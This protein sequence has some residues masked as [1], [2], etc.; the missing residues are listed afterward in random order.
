MKHLKKLLWLLP[1]SFMFFSCSNAV[2]E[3]HKDVKAVLKWEAS[4]VKTFEPSIPDT[5]P[6]DLVLALRHHSAVKG[7]TLP[8]KCT[9]Q[10]PSDFSKETWVDFAVRDQDGVLLGSVAGDICDTEMTFLSGFTF[11]EAGTYTIKVE[12]VKEDGN[13]IPGMMEVGLRVVPVGEE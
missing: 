1:L 10:G 5:K 3:E 11:P 9:M 4:D 6:Y 7:P 12:Q 13:P 2:F 8:L